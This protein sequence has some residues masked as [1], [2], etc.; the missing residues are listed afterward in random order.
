MNKI[1]KLLE[2]NKT[3]KWNQI[4]KQRERDSEKEKQG[5]NCMEQS[6]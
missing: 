3:N 4:W 5:R 2:A 6:S 1:I